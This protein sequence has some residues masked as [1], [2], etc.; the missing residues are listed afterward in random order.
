MAEPSPGIARTKPLPRELAIDGI[1]EVDPVL[2]ACCT[3]RLASLLH[4]MYPMRFETVNARATK[5]TTNQSRDS[6]TSATNANSD[7]AA[8]QK[9]VDHQNILLSIVGT[10]RETS[11]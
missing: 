11:G 4:F 5:Q 6:L 7:H 2:I 10:L 8:A 9:Y 1:M 3:L